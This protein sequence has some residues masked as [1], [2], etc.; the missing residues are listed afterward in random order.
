MLFF[1]VRPVMLELFGVQEIVTGRF[2]VDSGVIG[3]RI[4]SME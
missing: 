2:V 1:I 4:W 3:V